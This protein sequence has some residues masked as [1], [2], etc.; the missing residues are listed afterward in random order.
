MRLK[1]EKALGF[2]AIKIVSRRILGRYAT[3]IGD[4]GRFITLDLK[5]N[6]YEWVEDYANK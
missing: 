3:N 5:S 1:I 2:A 6:I 4:E